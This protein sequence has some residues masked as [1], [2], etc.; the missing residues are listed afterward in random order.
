M[1]S[2]DIS[3]ISCVS[4]KCFLR[5]SLCHCCLRSVNPVGANL[6][7]K[8]DLRGHL[9][10]GSLSCILVVLRLHVSILHLIITNWMNDQTARVNFTCG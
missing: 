3:D 1:L 9:V 4:G 10:W 6:E 8:S 5:H 2:L 7:A